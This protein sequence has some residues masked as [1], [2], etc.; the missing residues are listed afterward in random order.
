MASILVID[1]EPVIRLLV[2]KA[3]SLRGHTVLEAPDGIEGI[4]LAREWSPDLVVCDLAMPGL[5]GF[6]TI[7]AIRQ[8][9][10]SRKM[11]VLVLTVKTGWQTAREAKDAGAS[12]VINKPV[13][14]K[15]LAAKI[16]ALLRRSGGRRKQSRIDGASDRHPARVVEQRGERGD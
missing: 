11:P 16:D 5:D 7:R 12:E 14:M 3:L 8:D 15:D 4:R 13:D 9:H 10:K 2:H 1:D 6:D